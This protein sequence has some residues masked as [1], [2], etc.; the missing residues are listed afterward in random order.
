MCHLHLQKN[1]ALRH[2]FTMFQ[3]FENLPMFVTQEHTYPAG[4]FIL[5]NRI[6]THPPRKQ[7]TYLLS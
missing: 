2:R 6:L 7:T 4:S 3:I 1:G 5:F